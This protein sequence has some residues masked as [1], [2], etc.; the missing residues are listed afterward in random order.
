MVTPECPIPTAAAALQPAPHL[1]SRAPDC[2]HR[3]W[4][5]QPLPP[6]PTHLRVCPVL[7]RFVCS[8]ERRECARWLKQPGRQAGRRPGRQAGR[9]AGLRRPVVSGQPPPPA[10]RCW[11][12]PC[13]RAARRR[14]RRRAELPRGGR[15]TQTCRPGDEAGRGSLHRQRFRQWPA[16]CDVPALASG[17]VGAFPT[18]DGPHAFSPGSP[19]SSPT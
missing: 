12:S 2:S 7:C 19:D 3:P 10:A 9:Q 14:R 17:A 6:P 13:R 15:C 1:T 16:I 5:L 8:C 18:F 4:F 11:C